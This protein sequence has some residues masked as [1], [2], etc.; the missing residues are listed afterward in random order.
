[1]IISSKVRGEGNC[2]E[3]TNRGE[4]ARVCAVKLTSRSSSATFTPNLRG[5]EQKRHVRPGEIP[6]RAVRGQRS[7]FR[8]TPT[9]DDALAQILQIRLDAARRTRH[10]MCSERQLQ[11]NRH[12][13][14][15]ALIRGDP[16]DVP[17][18]LIYQQSGRH[19]VT[20]CRVR[21]KSAVVVVPISRLQCEREGL[22]NSEQERTIHDLDPF[23][24]RSSGRPPL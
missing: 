1:M 2:G 17:E 8:R 24:R 15:H 16:W 9:V 10:F 23:I 19:W 20:D 18:N 13:R 22:N 11:L 14:V 4:E 5:D 12:W 21:W 7:R 3:A 6:R